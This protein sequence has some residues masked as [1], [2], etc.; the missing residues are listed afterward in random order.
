MLVA[1]KLQIGINN[2]VEGLS[3]YAC[4]FA[5]EEKIMEDI[6]A[7]EDCRML[8]DDMTVFE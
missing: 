6:K 5:D 8:Q 3:S 4:W 7:E 2:K 1:I